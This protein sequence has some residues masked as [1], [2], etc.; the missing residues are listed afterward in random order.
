MPTDAARVLEDVPWN[1]DVA[2]DAQA[3]KEVPR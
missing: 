2:A 1:P 3:A